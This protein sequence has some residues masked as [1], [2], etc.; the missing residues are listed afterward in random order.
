MFGEM[1]EFASN[2]EAEIFAHCWEGHQDLLLIPDGRSQK[3]PR[4]EYPQRWQNPRQ[5]PFRPPF[6]NHYGQHPRQPPPKS[7]PPLDQSGAAARGS[8]QPAETRQGLH[9]L[10]ETDRGRHPRLPHESGERMAPTEDPGHLGSPISDATEE[11]KARDQSRMAHGFLG[12]DIQNVV[13]HRTPPEARL[14]ADTTAAHR[15]STHPKLA[16]RAPEWRGDTALRLHGPAP[17]AGTTGSSDGDVR[18]RNLIARTDGTGDVTS[19]AC[20]GTH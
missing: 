9:A 20:V 13:P 12:V 7:A 1:P 2:E 5:Q 6:G 16:A 3:R 11:N 8:D 17:E 14:Q 19:A 15:G 4:P 18:P 10:H